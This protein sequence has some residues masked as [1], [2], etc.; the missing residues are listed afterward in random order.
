MLCVQ[1]DKHFCTGIVRHPQAR[2]SAD[3]KPQNKAPIHH[4]YIEHHLKPVTLYIH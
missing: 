1:M 2:V 4:D 3:H